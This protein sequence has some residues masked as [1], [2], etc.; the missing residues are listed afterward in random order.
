[1][2]D[3]AKTLKLAIELTVCPTRCVWH[4]LVPSA[5]WCA[6]LWSACN[7]GLDLSRLDAQDPFAAPS[8]PAAAADPFGAMGD[9]AIT[10]E[11]D[12]GGAAAPNAAAAANALKALE[13]DPDP[14]VR[15]LRASPPKTPVEFAEALEWMTRIRRW[16]EVDRY[17]SVLQSANWSQDKL[18]ELSQAGGAALWFKLRDATTDLKEP[19]RNFVRDIAALPAKLA[20]DPQWIDSW[21]DRLVAPTPGER[22]EAQLRL[23][24]AHHASVERLCLHLMAGHPR[25]PGAVLVEAILEFNDDGIAALRTACIS[26]DSAARWRVLIALAQSTATDFG[27]ELGSALYSENSPAELRTS[28]SDALLKKYGK[29]PTAQAV[30]DYITAR[31]NRHLEE[32]QLLRT[33]PARMP[34]RLWRLSSDGRSVAAVDAPL[35]DHALESL[36]QAATHRA[37]FANTAPK[38][39]IDCAA[40]LAQHMYQSALTTP[41][42]NSLLRQPQNS[43]FWKQ[44]LD[45]SVVWQMHGASIVAAEAIGK[46]L[47]QSAPGDVSFDFIAGCLRDSRPVMRYLA[48]Q[49]IAA[50][51]VSFAY[52]GSAN[53]L[54]TAIEMSRLGQGPM[55]LVVGLSPDL[56]FAAQQQLLAIGAEAVTV[57][58][59][60]DALQVLDQPY[61]IE[62][63]MFVDRLPRNS[64]LTCVDRLR[65]SKRGGALP[66]AILTDDMDPLE[67]S[68][69]SKT[70]G[71]VMSV[72]S[73]SPGQMPR[74]IAELERRL[75]TRPLTS[76]ERNAYAET[77]NQLSAKIASDRRKYGF[78]SLA[79]WEKEL[80]SI[81]GVLPNETYLAVLGGIGTIASQ[82]HLI[83]IA[84]DKSAGQ[85]ARERA[86]KAFTSSTEV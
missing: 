79:R 60:A 77:A 26:P 37:A 4:R 28:L 36:A 70:P 21:I 56:R 47:V 53:A 22:R 2:I 46:Q 64:I 83:A 1:M 68:E 84:A 12:Q 63:I 33:R 76:A 61:P 23:Q 34:L 27:A 9:A 43:N 38:E 49:A 81:S 19:Q 10:N 58:S 25:V 41:P 29:L 65:H 35:P 18:A 14:V 69:L 17:L 72:L 80:E 39:L 40:V 24:R 30:G 85:D 48:V 75:D 52:N 51:N 44:V 86:A 73:E 8:D 45:R 7:V 74:V 66:V 42:Q 20:R 71:V 54:E 11:M 16:D 5:V 13:E 82:E 55:V 57:N 50:A 67:R 32:Y 3:L 15:L 31:F 78:Y 6:A 59:T 62:M